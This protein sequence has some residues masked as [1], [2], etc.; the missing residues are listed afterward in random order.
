MLL[1]DSV[2]K[3]IRKQLDSL[4]AVR[5]TASDSTIYQPRFDPEPI[6]RLQREQKARE[7]RAAITRI[8]FGAALLALLV[9]GWVRREKIRNRK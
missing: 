2:V 6:L 5:M 8:A 1:S 9:L 3:N 7:R 4:P